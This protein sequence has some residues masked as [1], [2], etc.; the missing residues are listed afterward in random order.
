MASGFAAPA[1]F[2]GVLYSVLGKNHFLL[3]FWTSLRR[4]SI[5]TGFWT[6]FGGM[7]WTLCLDEKISARTTSEIPG[8]LFRKSVH[9]TFYCK[10]IDVPTQFLGGNRFLVVHLS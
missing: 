2:R 4:K 3:G 1:G 7:T 10:N 9:L 8:F 6:D 5:F